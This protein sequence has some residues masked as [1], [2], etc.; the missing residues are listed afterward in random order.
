MTKSE[1][2][3]K[4]E[5]RNVSPSDASG[6]RHSSFV[7]RHSSLV[8][9]P[10]TFKFRRPNHAAILVALLWC[11]ALLSVVVIGVL[12]TAR[13]HLMIGKNHTDRI[14]ARY[15]ALAGIEKAKALLYQDAIERRRAAKNHTGAFYDAPEEFREIPFGPGKFSVLRRGRGDEGSGIIF[16]VSD[17]EG[18]LN[19]N[20]AQPEELVK[21]YGLTADMVAAIVDWK[22]EDDNVSPGGAEAE[23]YSTLR[24][25]YVPRNGPLQS[26]R[27]LLMVRGISRE[28]LLGNDLTQN[29]LLGNGAEGSARGPR[30]VPLDPGLGQALTVDGWTRNVNAEGEARVNIQTADEGALTSVHGI[31]R[32]I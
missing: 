32:E 8:R 15:L 10:S 31:T 14:Q 5:I 30:N 28:L 19:V 24:P 4:S 6:F 20:Q 3:T 21:L 26:V 9:R 27:E 2:M 18:R 16:G 22:D 12:H 29:G 13:L 7:I 1:R 23:Y 11:V 25:P 17:E